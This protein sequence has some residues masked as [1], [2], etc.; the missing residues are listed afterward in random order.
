MMSKIAVSWLT[1]RRL[2]DWRT[3]FNLRLAG[4]P[5]KNR[6]S[7]TQLS[8]PQAGQLVDP[9][10]KHISQSRQSTVRFRG[11]YAGGGATD[12]LGR[13]VNITYLICGDARRFANSAIAL[14]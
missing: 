5:S 1:C 4:A 2:E 13:R 8:D 11:M 7:A 6:L 12:R 14:C 3:M 10:P 9:I